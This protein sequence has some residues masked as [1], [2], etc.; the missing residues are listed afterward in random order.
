MR[1]RSSR[2]TSTA[3]TPGQRATPVSA[4]GRWSTC[5][6]TRLKSTSGSRSIRTIQG[7]D[8]NYA[9]VIIGR[10]LRYDRERQALVFDRNHYYDAK[11]K[12]NNRVRG[13]SYT[14]EDILRFVRNI[15]CV[16]LT[17]GMLGTYVYVCDPDLRE[18]L[19]PYLT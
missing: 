7:Y 1:S 5:S 9:G 16:L 13:I 11:G 19:R 2:S 17:R 8:L 18:H 15:Y 3:S 14:D 12:E 10:D 4:T 6:T